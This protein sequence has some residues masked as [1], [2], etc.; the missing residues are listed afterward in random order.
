MC[1]ST[2]RRL[3]HMQHF[4]FSIQTLLYVD[5]NV[6]WNPVLG[7]QSHYSSRQKLL[8]NRFQCLL[9]ELVRAGHCK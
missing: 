5:S 3:T 7:L 2:H 8:E 6:S 4:Y 9:Q 1:T